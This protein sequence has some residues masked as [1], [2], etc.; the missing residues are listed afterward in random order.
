MW[1]SPFFGLSHIAAFPQ[2]LT[3]RNFRGLFDLRIDTP[4]ILPIE[5]TAEILRSK[6]LVEQW[7]FS[8]TRSQSRL[9]TSV[10]VG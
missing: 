3:G 1:E 7:H 10:S 4:S 8:I 6:H 9:G 2:L 5:N